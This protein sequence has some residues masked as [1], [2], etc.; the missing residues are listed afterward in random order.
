MG[1]LVRSG[2]LPGGIGVKNVYMTFSDFPVYIMPKGNGQYEIRGYYSVYPSE[3]ER[4][5]RDTIIDLISSV[6]DV[7]GSLHA[8]LYLKLKEVYPDSENIL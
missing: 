7:S 5:Q 2:T 1:L 6:T 8:M 4:K 3:N